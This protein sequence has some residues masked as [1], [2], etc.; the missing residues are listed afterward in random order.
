FLS[1]NELSNVGNPLLEAMR[2]GRCIVT[3]DEGDTR[4]LIRDDETGV[5]LPSGDPTTVANA[6]A[7]L[8]VD[9]PRRTRLGEAAR[10]S[11]EANF[12]SWQQRIDA[13]VD[14]LE[15]LVAQT[16]PEAAHV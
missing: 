1:L 8:A 2:T 11:A 16:K 3:L 15:Q 13:E 14:A 10:Q 9:P 4:D 5:L 12:W 7:S 6:L